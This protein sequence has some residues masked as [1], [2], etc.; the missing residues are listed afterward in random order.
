MRSESGCLKGR[1]VVSAIPLCLYVAAVCGISAQT[2]RTIPDLTTSTPQS[3]AE[4][5]ADN[6][7]RIIADDGNFPLRYRIRKVDSKNDTTRDVIESRQGAVARLLQRDGRPISAAEDSAERER[8]NAMLGSPGDFARHHKR[9]LAARSYSMELI[10]QMPRA[11]IFTYAPGQPQRPN[12]AGPQVVID[13]TPDPRYHPPALIDDALTGLQ[14][15]IWIDRKSRRVLRIE[16]RVL[17]AVDFGWGMLARVYPGG[18]VEFEQANAGGDRWAYSHLRE[19]ITVREMMLKTVRQ[20]AEMDAADFQILP[21]PV[22]YQ[23]AIRILLAT[24]IPLR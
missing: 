11:M 6:E 20:H 4:A 3:W 16:G 1:S 12:F 5:A 9:D 18:T 21:A 19:N 8:L 2:V 15:R 24:P 10:R 14:G 13:F 17:H 22:D 23:E 7:Q